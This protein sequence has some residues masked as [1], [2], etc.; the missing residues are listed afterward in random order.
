MSD[1]FCDPDPWLGIGSVLVSKYQSWKNIFGT[2]ITFS[3][4]GKEKEVQ[5]DQA[6]SSASS[7]WVLDQ[8]ASLPPEINLV[9][10]LDDRDPQSCQ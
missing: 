4:A 6:L 9:T 5:L 8:L 2:L 1:C 10:S 7:S 3:V